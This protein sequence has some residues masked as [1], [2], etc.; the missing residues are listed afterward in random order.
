MAARSPLASSSPTPRS[1]HAPHLADS[2]SYR[3]RERERDRERDV[4]RT[5]GYGAAAAMNSN[6]TSSYF[7]QQPA[8]P[9]SSY[10][11]NAAVAS[12]STPPRQTAPLRYDEDR[13]TQYNTLANSHNVHQAQHLPPEGDVA[14]YDNPDANNSTNLAVPSATARGKFTEEWD[15]SQRGSS[16]I[17]GHSS[18]MP[19]SNSFVSN[20]GEDHLSLPSRHNTL[21]KKNSLRRNGSLKRS[22]SRR[23][24]K[25]GS[26]RSLALQSSNDPDEI[27]SAFHCPVPTSGNP[28]EALAARFQSW[29]KILKDLIAY[30]REIQ[31]YYEHK[32][33]SLLKLA[34]VANNIASPPGF[35]DSGGIDDALQI[36][37]SYHKGAILESNKAKDIEE[38]VILALTGLRNDLHQKIKEIKNLSGDFKNSVDKEMDST[39]RAVKALQ[40]TLGQTDLDPSLTTGKQDPYLL[41]LA[42]DRQ[43]ERQ[44]DEENYLHQAYLNLENSG[45]ELEAIVVGEVQKAYNAYAGIIKRESDAAYNAIEELRVGPISMPKDHEWAHFVQKDDQFVDPDIPI[46]SAEH[47]HYPGREHVACQ[48]I[49]AGLLERKSKYLKSYTAGWYVLSSTHLHEFKSADKGQAPVMS[50]YLPEQKLGSHS[51][52]GGSS[53]KFILKGRQTGSMHRGH[54]WVFRAESHDTMMAWYED[55]KVLTER[56]PQERSEF[57]RGHVRSLSQSSQRSTSSD[58]V[59][60]DDDD[61]PFSADA[62]VAASTSSRQDVRRPEAGGRFPSDIQVNAQ[63]G[64][65]APLSPSSV[66]SGFDN[67]DRDAVMQSSTMPDSILGVYHGSNEHPNGYGGTDRTPMEEIPSHAAVVTQQAREDGVNPYTRESLRRSQSLTRRQ[68]AVYVPAAGMQRAHSQHATPGRYEDE[69][70]PV[71]TAD[72]DRVLETP[73]GNG[74]YGQWMNSNGKSSPG[75]PNNHF[76]QQEIGEY[77]AS[78]GRGLGEVD[79]IPAIG[80]GNGHAPSNEHPQQDGSSVAAAASSIPRNQDAP[81]QKQTASSVRPTSG[82]VRNDSVPTISNLHIPGEYPKGNAAAVES[83]R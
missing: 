26:V 39:K 6:R 79:I 8:Q 77:S 4:E 30:Y 33:K 74:Q 16:I 50:L 18:N 2:D 1:N 56:S 75:I 49:R 70:R 25:A 73:G 13:E 64:L 58:G 43:V 67:S 47:I 7:P 80:T 3:E 65:Q 81:R 61:E 35:L 5:A 57:V 9:S 83:R 72:Y 20:N 29:R 53:N 71:S 21:K 45:R 82:T 69:S 19:R 12:Y 52:E 51:S 42:V 38:D 76:A 23:S 14:Y 11:S 34:N 62:A 60:E 44:I 22:S 15:A 28:T 27:H 59:L 32:S 46:R 48:E 63:R 68:Q 66:S 40:D 37:R 24:M 31:S 78:G 54:T 36:L 41:R 10:T 17:E 55:I